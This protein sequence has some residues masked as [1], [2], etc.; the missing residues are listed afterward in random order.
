MKSAAEQE[1]KSRGMHRPETVVLLYVSNQM[2][3]N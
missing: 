1:P 2:F 3:A